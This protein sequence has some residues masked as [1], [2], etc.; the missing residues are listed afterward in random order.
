MRPQGSL[1]TAFG[2]CGPSPPSKPSPP[3]QPPQRSV[4]SNYKH[5]IILLPPSGQGCPTP[6]QVHVYFSSEICSLG[7][8]SESLWWPP[9]TRSGPPTLGIL[10]VP[11]TVGTLAVSVLQTESPMRPRT[12]SVCCHGFPRVHLV[13]ARGLRKPLCTRL[14]QTQC[15]LLSPSFTESSRLV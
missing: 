4:I 1:P 10:R 13:L 3:P 12:G 2:L 7:T 9:P 11:L 15:R 5:S 6:R 8:S 14:G